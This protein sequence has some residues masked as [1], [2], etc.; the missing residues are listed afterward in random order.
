VHFHLV[1]ISIDINKNYKV[2]YV[3]AFVDYWILSYRQLS[4]VP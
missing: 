2:V 3:C 4:N 1:F